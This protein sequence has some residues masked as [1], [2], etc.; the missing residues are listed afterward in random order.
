[1]IVV[2]IVIAAISKTPPTTSQRIG[3]PRKI[4]LRP[5]KAIM[6]SV[7]DPG[8]A[9][10]NAPQAVFSLQKRGYAAGMEVKLG[11]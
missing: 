9:G 3:L 7:I 8:A 2:P 11:T 4:F 6:L 1:M 10:V 5:N